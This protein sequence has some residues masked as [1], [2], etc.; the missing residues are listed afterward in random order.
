MIGSTIVATSTAFLLQ[1]TAFIGSPPNPEPNQE[2]GGIWVRGVG[3]E[4]SVKSNTSSSLSLTTGPTG[5]ASCFQ[6]VDENFAGVQFGK[7]IAELNVNGWN[8]HLGATAGYLASKGNLVGGAFA[9]TN[10]G[11][12]GGGGPFNSTTQVPFIGAYAAATYGGFAIDALVRTEYYQNTLNAPGASLFNQNIDARGI[13]FAASAQY[14]WKVPNS[15]WFI[16]PSAGI[17]I[18]RIKVDPFNFLTSGIAGGTTLD[19]TLRLNEIHSDIGRLGLRFGTTINSGPVIWQPFAAVSVWHEFGQNITSNYATTPGAVVCGG[20]LCTVFATSSTSTIGTFGQYSLGVSAQLAGTGWLGFARVDYR[21]G[22]DLQGWSGTGGIRYQ[23]TPEGAP[24]HIMP[25][26]TKAPPPVVQAIN[27]TGFYVGVFGGATQ[28]TADWGYGVGEAAPHVGGYLFGG[29]VGYNYQTGPY[30]LGVDASIETTN[31]KGGTG[32]GTNSVEATPTPIP[33]KFV[34]S[35]MFQ[36]TCNAWTNWLATATARAGYAWGRSL[37]Y[38]KG[39]GAWTHEQFSATC[40]NGPNNAI[41]ELHFVGCS[42]P[43]NVFSNGLTAG[44]DRGGW[45]VGF[46]GEFALSANWSAKA[47]TNYISFGDTNVTASDGS[48]LKV[49]MHLWEEKIGVNYRF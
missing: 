16:E 48:L 44:S 46:G 20:P 2:G 13:T 5:S 14:Q 29:D 12:P 41:D 28:G 49:G 10:Q 1:S 43:A 24:K 47:E 31:T 22:S 4:V 45:V 37:W 38:V 26:K 35:P 18:S 19:G 39:G 7:D 36:M 32:C 21:D 11:I 25:I 23:F 3:G 17:I 33:T 8:L 42:N 34:T 6:K 15:D 27:W 9:F 40:N 30:V